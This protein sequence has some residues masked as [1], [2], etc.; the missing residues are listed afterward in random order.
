[1][2]A[3]LKESKPHGT[4]EY[5]YTQYHIRKQKNTFHVPVHWHEEMELIYISHGKLRVSIEGEVYEGLPGNKI[6]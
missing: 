3:G 4:K 2:Y 5:P 1:M 6:V